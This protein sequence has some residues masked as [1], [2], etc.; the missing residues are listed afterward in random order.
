MERQLSGMSNTPNGLAL[1]C[2]ALSLV[3]APAALCDEPGS[4]QEY[5]IKAAFLYNFLKFVDWP[6]EAMPDGNEP[7]T[8]GIIGKDPFG[9]A[10]EPVKDKDVRGKK[11]VVKR[12][13]SIADLKKLGE[14]GKDELDRQI[15]AVKKCHLL[16]V[17][18]SEKEYLKDIVNAVKYRPVLT[19]GDTEEFLQSGGI[20]SFVMEDQ[21]VRF[22][23]NLTAAEHAKLKIRSQ[24]LRLAKRVIEEKDAP[25]DNDK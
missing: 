24:L 18:S 15:E 16:F 9:Q 2:V 19:V 13:K 8:I 7:V 6:K 14:S 17:C 20:I 1:L 23:V 12:F 21:K 5:Q 11:V 3:C 25:E 10:F 4:I 22:E